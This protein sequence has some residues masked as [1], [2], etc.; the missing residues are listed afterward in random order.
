MTVCELHLTMRH[1]ILIL[2]LFISAGI[3][4]SQAPAADMSCPPKMVFN[5]AEFP[6]VYKNG[7]EKM[8]AFFAEAAAELVPPNA[9]GIIELNMI[10]C[11]QDEA[12]LSSLV[13]KTDMFVD[14]MQWKRY[15]E[16]FKGWKAGRQNGRY[17][18]FALTIILEI[19][20]G[21]VIKVKYN[22]GSKTIESALHRFPG[23]TYTSF[24]YVLV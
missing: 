1:T 21:N 9:N 3:C 6:P 15:I 17:I 12:M 23:R 13:N 19:R 8:K 22:D 4:Y 18:S 11:A 2:L 20:H 16:D 5:K 14:T 7:A 10:I 24:P